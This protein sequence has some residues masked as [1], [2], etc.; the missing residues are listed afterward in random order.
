MSNPNIKNIITHSFQTSDGQVFACYQDAVD[1][2]KLLQKTKIY[3]ILQFDVSLERVALQ[4]P[5]TINVKI[6]SNENHELYANL[7]AQT[8]IGMK[9]QGNLNIL[10]V[11]VWNRWEVSEI[12]SETAQNTSKIHI[13]FDRLNGNGVELGNTEHPQYNTFKHLIDSNN[14]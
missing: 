13:V 4:F 12:V 9:T 3:K 7:I 11:P 5:L 8:L 6:I 10:D 1:H 14:N 2:D